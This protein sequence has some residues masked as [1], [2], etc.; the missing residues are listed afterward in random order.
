[1][2]RVGLVDSPRF[3][4]HDPGPGRPEQVNRLPAI[5]RALDEQGLLERLVAVEPRPVDRTLLERIHQPAYVQRVDEFCAAGGGMIDDGDTMVGA[6]S[7]SVAH[8]AAGGAVA[9]VEAVMAGDL[10][11]AFALVR[12]PGHHALADAAMGFCLFN[13]VA[14]MAERARQLG[15]GRVL[16]LDWDVH[17]GNGTEA[18]F[19]E[20]DDVL[21]VSWHQQPLWPHTGAVADQGQGQGLGYTMNL[22]MPKGAGDKAYWQ[23]W[24]EVIVPLA[25]GY[26]PDLILLS[27]GFDAHWRDPLAE[28]QLSVPGYARMAQALVE[29]ADDVAGGRLVGVLE[30]GYDLPALAHAA[31]AT[32]RQF[33][34]ADGQAVDPFGPPEQGA[35]DEVTDLIG[36]LQ[37]THPRLQD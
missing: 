31:A 11:R 18:L 4:R 37:R 35:L 23:T 33:L 20:R 16:I 32:V 29:L 17:H 8:L 36:L 22:P 25:R 7:A 30:G 15:A 10:D 14:V 12:P 5:R 13:N 28:I 2:A 1:M 9:A 24:R 34:E 21:V 3:D 26:R 19:A 27:A 6:E